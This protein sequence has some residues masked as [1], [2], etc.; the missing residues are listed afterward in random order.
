MIRI[1]DKTTCAGCSA[2]I[3][4]CPKQCIAWE[5]DNEGFKY[6]SV[7][8]NI[9][10]DCH[11][12]E[13]VCPVL[14]TEK[15]PQ[16]EVEIYAAYCIDEIIRK[17]SSSGGIFSILAKSVL[18][19]GGCVYGAAFDESFNVKHVCIENT[20]DIKRLRGSKY[21]QSDIGDCI[22]QAKHQL[23][24][25]RKVLFSGCPCQV[26]G[27]INSVG[28]K[29]R[30]NLLTVDFIC[31]GVPSPKIY[32]MYVEWMGRRGEI[33]QLSF[34]DKE[35][36]WKTF[37]FSVSYRNGGRYS[38]ILTFDKYLQ[39][40]LRN[41]ILRP[42][43][44]KCKQIHLSDLTLADYWTIAKEIPKMNDDQGVSMVCV[45]TNNG[46]QMWDKIKD[47]LH[48]SSRGKMKP[49][50]QKGRPV[51]QKRT[52]LFEDASKLS[53]DVLY[54]KHVKRGFLFEFGNLVK[55]YTKIALHHLHLYNW[56]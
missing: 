10:I 28:N 23:M 13:R 30:E 22:N 17:E 46:Q 1:E 7:D 34:R 48:Y 40:F 52:A 44:Y 36:G 33:E 12:C 51:P 54:S 50:N 41:I 25:G 38:K 37:S 20:I 47:N 39:M 14:H 53:F 15:E 27:L 55:G 29:W 42:S 43:C 9:C 35:C 8:C 45:N 56:G 2:C 16:K 19:E 18:D 4:S 31:H 5:T 24:K 26:N 49:K 3:I 6:P 32:Q 11:L 21:V